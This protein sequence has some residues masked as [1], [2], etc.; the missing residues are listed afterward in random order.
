MRCAAEPEASYSPGTH[1][2]DAQYRIAFGRPFAAW[3]GD[4]D[5]LGHVARIRKDAL[6]YFCALMKEPRRESGENEFPRPWYHMNYRHPLNSLLL[7]LQMHDALPGTLKENRSRRPLQSAVP[8]KAPAQ[9]SRIS[10]WSLPIEVG[11]RFDVEPT[12]SPEVVREAV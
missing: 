9:S 1:G 11:R 10:H 5:H 3:S 4:R 6:P 2:R 12:N 8:A 7:W